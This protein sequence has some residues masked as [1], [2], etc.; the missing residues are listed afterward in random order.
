MKPRILI[1]E[2]DEVLREIYALRLGMEGFEVATA[3]DGVDGLTQVDQIHPQLIILD[4]LMPRLDG[5]GFLQRYYGATPPGEGI[6]L[7]ASNKS[8]S[9][10]IAQ[11]EKLGAVAYLIKSHLT[12]DQLVTYVHKYLPPSTA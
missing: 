6:V 9:R 10:H 11:A 8:S 4:M 2:D 1:V 3:I 12:P 7:V 5:L